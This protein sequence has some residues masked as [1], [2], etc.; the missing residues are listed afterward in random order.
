MANPTTTQANPLEM[1]AVVLTSTTPVTVY[2]NPN[3]VYELTHL[4][5]DAGA[6]D[7]NDSVM[8]GC[9]GTTAAHSEGDRKLILLDLATVKVFGV[10]VITL[11][12]VGNDPLVNIQPLPQ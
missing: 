12:A 5:V 1:P 8:I 11:D 4:G 3:L 9:E 6:A 7:T 2:L 10:S